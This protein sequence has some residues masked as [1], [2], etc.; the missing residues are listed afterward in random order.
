MHRV[1]PAPLVESDASSD[2]LPISAVALVVCGGALMGWAVWTFRRARTAIYPN[3]PAVRVVREGPFR[4]TRNPM[5]V[6]MALIY[7][8]LT[9]VLNSRWPLLFLPIVLVALVRLVIRREES[10]LA[11]AFATEYANYCRQVR[12]WV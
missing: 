4:F 7:L 9:A 5:Y 6:G 1:I 8:G 2:L 10:Y 11:A 3:R 12:R